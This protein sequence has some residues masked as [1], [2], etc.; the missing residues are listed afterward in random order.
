MGPGVRVSGV[1]PNLGGTT[2]VPS[3]PNGRRG[4]FFG[5]TA[6]EVAREIARRFN[7]LY[8]QVF[9]EPDVLIG[10]VPS[11]PGTD[12][13]SKM[14]KS[15]G[16]AI[17]LSNDAATVEAKVKMMY[18]DPAQLRSTDPGTVEGNPVF[19]Y[20]E[21]FNPDKDEVADLKERYRAGRV[22]DVEVKAKLSRAL[23]AFLDPIRERRAYYLT[24]PLVVQDALADG[25]IVGSACV[26][27]LGESADPVQ[28]TI[29]FARTLKA[30]LAESLPA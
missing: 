2:G 19:I 17:F 14:S 30:A 3:R 7:L 1:Q 28:A 4:F 21:A 15:L 24:H 11:L 27:A 18:T 29:G 10:E 6:V 16:N 12:G 26:P 20:H 25:I 23:N 9:P 13:N 22:G 8:G 5:S